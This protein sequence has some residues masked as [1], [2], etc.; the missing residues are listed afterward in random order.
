MEWYHLG[1][2][3]Q[4][5]LDRSLSASLSAMLSDL[6]Q[7]TGVTRSIAPTFLYFSCLPGTRQ[8]VASASCL[9]RT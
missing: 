6:I 7:R 3:S 9:A 4:E 1:L 2:R 5:W 8:G